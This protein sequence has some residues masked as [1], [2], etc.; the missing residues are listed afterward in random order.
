MPELL[1]TDLRVPSLTMAKPVNRVPGPDLLPGGSWYGPEWDGFRVSAV[2]TE[3]GLT[4][5]SCQGKDLN[6]WF[7]DLAAV[8]TKQVPTGCVIDGEA[9]ICPQAGPPPRHLPPATWRGCR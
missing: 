5:W 4:L 9:L 6:G 7:A 2:V 8:L 3:T 1:P